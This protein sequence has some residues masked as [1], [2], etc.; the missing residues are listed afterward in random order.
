M[1]SKGQV[2]V[3]QAIRRRLGI[4]PGDRLSFIV[5]EDGVIEVQPE[6]GD[7]MALAGSLKP[8]V[9]GVTLADMDAAIA[10]GASGD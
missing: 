6:T 3:P 9:R 7:L 5:R 1:T 2:T 10:A 4:G 8:R